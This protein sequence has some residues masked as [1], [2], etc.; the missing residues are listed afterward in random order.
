MGGEAITLEAAFPFS[1]PCH[2]NVLCSR[3]LLDVGVAISLKFTFSCWS[4]SFRRVLPVGTLYPL[5]PAILWVVGVCFIFPLVK[6]HECSV[7]ARAMFTVLWLCFQVV[8][9]GRVFGL[10]L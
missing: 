8:H 3:A 1:S 5:F 4:L 2:T 6:L 7:K 9:L 10:C